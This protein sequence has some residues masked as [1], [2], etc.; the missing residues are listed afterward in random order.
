MGSACQLKGHMTKHKEGNVNYVQMFKCDVCDILI[1]T[2]GLLRRHM[3][4]EHGIQHVI[5]QEN[6]PGNKNKTN[7]VKHSVKCDLCSYK[8]ETKTKLTEHLDNK[9]T[10]RNHRCEECGMRADNQDQLNRHIK[11]SHAMMRKKTTCKF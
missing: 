6:N 3:R 7:Y 10:Q 2:V 8:A 4:C 1:K 9:H 5:M 11:A